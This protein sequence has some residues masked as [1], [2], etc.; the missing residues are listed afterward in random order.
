MYSSGFIVS[1]P[2]DETFYRIKSFL[3]SL[4]NSRLIYC[5]RATGKKLYIRV[6]EGDN[7]CL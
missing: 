5:T 4:E 1:I 3:E 2:D 7:G 6:E